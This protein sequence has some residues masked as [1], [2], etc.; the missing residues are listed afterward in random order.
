[1]QTLFIVCFIAGVVLSVLSFASGIHRLH[2][3]RFIR[4]AGKKRAS[5]LNGA[6][7]I[8]FLTWFGGGGLLA[9]RLTTLL[10]VID[11]AIATLAGAGGAAAV[12]AVM[13]ALARRESA[14]ASLSMIGVIGRTVVPIREGEGTG[15]IVFT[16]AGTR[17]VAG[18][19]S[20]SGRAVPKGTE[21]VVTRYERGIAYVLSWD[22]L[23][24]ER[25]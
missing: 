1:M 8:A 18:A 12:N 9:E 23:E 20:E 19:R 24:K 6:A 11:L 22:E 16:H 21:V 4:H 2:L 5:M 3:P 17:R 10:H 13:N 14:A 15:E 25:P 7:L